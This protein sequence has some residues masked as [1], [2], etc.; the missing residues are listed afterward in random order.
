MIPFFKQNVLNYKD[1]N[2]DRQEDI[3]TIDLKKSL[4]KTIHATL[5]DKL[6]K[7]ILKNIDFNNTVIPIMLPKLE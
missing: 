4:Q 6:S 7:R 3:S 1:K 5:T 2:N